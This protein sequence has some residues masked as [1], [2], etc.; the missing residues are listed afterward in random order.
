M[1]SPEAFNGSLGMSSFTQ[2]A[3]LTALVYITVS[4]IFGNSSKQLEA[5]R[6][7]LRA[8]Y[9]PR[10]LVGLRFAQGASSMIEEGYCKV[11]HRTPVRITQKSVDDAKFKDSW[12]QLARND[13]D[14]LVLSNKYID[15]PRGLPNTWIS[16]IQALIAVSCKSRRSIWFRC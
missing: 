8:A 15:E 2:G 11:T 10:W 16:A 12:F 1:S 5:P 14:I 4:I 13:C 3:L 9:E 6:V 7:G